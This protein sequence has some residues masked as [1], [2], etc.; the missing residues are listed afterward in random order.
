MR[1]FETSNT[2]EAEARGRKCREECPRR[3]A[4][5]KPNRRTQRK[6]L[7]GNDVLSFTD[8]W[9]VPMGCPFMDVL[10]LLRIVDLK[11]HGRYKLESR[12]ENDAVSGASPPPSVGIRPGSPHPSFPE[13]ISG[14][15]SSY[16][17]S[18]SPVCSSLHG[19][20]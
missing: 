3:P 8:W 19:T 6:R 10:K 2:E 1:Q 5:V 9:T 7:W 14:V 17:H 4:T 12:P 15:A 13:L 20:A 11:T 18:C 16:G